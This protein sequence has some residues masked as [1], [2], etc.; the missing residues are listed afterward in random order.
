[1]IAL[2]A[3]WM[4]WRWKRKK[5]EMNE[6]ENDNDKC[7]KSLSVRFDSEKNDKIAYWI[8]FV[9]L[10]FSY[11]FYV[12]F[13]CKKSYFE[14]HDLATVVRFIFVDKFYESI[15]KF[16]TW[17]N[18]VW[19]QYCN[20]IRGYYQKSWKNERTCIPMQFQVAPS[21]LLLYLSIG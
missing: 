21:R 17:N 11:Y 1:M 13:L 18:A 2:S 8:Y 15:S 10:L 6:N 16:L 3:W 19:R 12:V 7:V 4:C 20:L 9:N 5:I 14:T